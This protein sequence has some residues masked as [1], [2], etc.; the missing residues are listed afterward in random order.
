MFDVVMFVIEVGV[1][2]YGIYMMCWVVV[3]V[4]VCYCEDGLWVRVEICMY[5]MM[6]DDFVYVELG[7]LLKIVLF[8][9]KEDDVEV[10]FEYFCCG[11]LSVVL[12]DYVVLK[13]VD[14][15]DWLWW[16]GLFGVNGV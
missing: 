9:C 13:C 12:M 15:V 16:E 1:K 3:D 10:M 2:Y 7:N 5:Y 11:V 14:K 8:I 4:F 6:F